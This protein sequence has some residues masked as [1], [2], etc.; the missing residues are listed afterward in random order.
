MD[1]GMVHAAGAGH[2]AE[3]QG[4][5]ENFLR[6]SVQIRLEG[7]AVFIPEDGRVRASYVV[8]TGHPQEPV[9]NR[10]SR[11]SLSLAT[12]RERADAMAGANDAAELLDVEVDEFAG[13]VMLV[14]ITPRYPNVY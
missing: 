12:T 11:Q 10:R 2:A 1:E 6:L 8:E 14:A 7:G 9:R 13:I 3:A 5:V 4:D